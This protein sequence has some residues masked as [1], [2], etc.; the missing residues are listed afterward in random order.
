MKNSFFLRFAVAVILGFHSIPS[1]F[2]MDVIQFGQNYLGNQGF[3]IM[4]VPFAIII[5]VIHL[6]AIFAL[7]FNKFIV[8]ISVL[9]IIILVAVIIMIHWQ[10]GWY[11]VGGGR[12][13]MEFNFLLIF[14]FLTFIFPDGISLRKKEDL[15]IS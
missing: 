11:V 9:N 1:F 10:E 2:T 8:P 3:G 12:N 14:C 15:P 13:G 5:K 4:G 7:L 6:V